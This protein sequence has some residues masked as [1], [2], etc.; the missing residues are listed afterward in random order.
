MFITAQQWQTN[1]LRERGQKEHWS[2]TLTLEPSHLPLWIG[3]ELEWEMS[4][5]PLSDL[6]PLLIP[7][8]MSCSQLTS[9]CVELASE[10]KTWW[11]ALCALVNCCHHRI[12]LTPPASHLGSFVP[13]TPRMWCEVMWWVPGSSC[14]VWHV[15]LSFQPLEPTI[16]AE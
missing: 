4:W 16:T 5:W 14:S 2:C 6:W 8:Q 3:E 7:V 1:W 9:R 13:Q 10:G 15:G 12:A 11:V